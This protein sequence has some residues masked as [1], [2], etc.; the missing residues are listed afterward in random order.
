MVAVC[1]AAMEDTEAIKS[2]SL[3]V[4]CTSTDHSTRLDNELLTG[5]FSPEKNQVCDI[6]IRKPDDRRT[7]VTIH[8]SEQL[9]SSYTMKQDL[10]A[11]G[12]SQM[13]HYDS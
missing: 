13:T 2:L 4:V 5:I 7:P 11:S 3:A 10:Y 9:R 12:L 8:A 1:K 6:L